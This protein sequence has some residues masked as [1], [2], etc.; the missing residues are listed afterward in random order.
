M[1]E[2]ENVS[3]GYGMVQ[4]LWDVSFKINEKEGNKPDSRRQGNFSE[5]DRGR[6]F[7]LGSLHSN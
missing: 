7:A 1:L 5:N 4:I 6:E 3:A 2:V